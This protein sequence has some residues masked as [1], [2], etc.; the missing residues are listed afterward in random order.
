MN[1]AIKTFEDGSELTP[2]MIAGTFVVA[3]VGAAAIFFGCE[4][5]EVRATKKIRRNYTNRPL[6]QLVEV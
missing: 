2:L 5:R 3:A 1:N 4:W 6:Q